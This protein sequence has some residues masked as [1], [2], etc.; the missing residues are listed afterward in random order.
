[1]STDTDLILEALK[2]H[3]AETREDIHELRQATV[4]VADAAAD[5]GKSMARS[6][7]RHANHENSMGR[8]GSRLDDHED[9]LRVC[10][11]N[12]PAGSNARQDEDIKALQ[13]QAL[14]RGSSMSGGWKILTVIGGLLLGAFA[15]ASLM[16][17]VKGLL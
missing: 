9:R 2:D 7:E 11:K 6:E 10:E 3:R 12:V 4:R 15:L 8:I 16:I 13:D 14:A 5:I 17:R 1:V